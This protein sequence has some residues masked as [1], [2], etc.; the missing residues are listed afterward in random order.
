MHNRQPKRLLTIL[1]LLILATVAFAA[2]SGDNPAQTGDPVRQEETAPA[3]DREQTKDDGI[4]MPDQSFKLID[5]N[6]NGTLEEREFNLLL[7][8]ADIAN[9]GQFDTYDA[10]D[11]NRIDPEEFTTFL[12]D[13]G[14]AAA[15]E[16]PDAPGQAADPNPDA[17][18]GTG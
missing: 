9:Q 15:G 10:D 16:S 4:F 11:N 8:R 17:D 1:L 13:E 3:G 7:V 18:P 12:V 5:A 2:C 14:L 6:A